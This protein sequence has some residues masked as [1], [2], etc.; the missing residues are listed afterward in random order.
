MNI[1]IQV[2]PI[3][4]YLIKEK[5]VILDQKLSTKVKNNNYSYQEIKYSRELTDTHKY[6]QI[7]TSTQRY[8]QVLTDT[9]KYSQIL[10]STHRYSQILTSTH[11]YS[12]VLTST[13]RY[14]QI[15][16]DTHRYS[17]ILT[18]THKY[19]QVLTSTHK[20]SQVLTDTSTYKHMH[21]QD[22]YLDDTLMLFFCK[23]LQSENRKLRNNHFSMFINS[24]LVSQTPN[25]KISVAILLQP[26][27]SEVSTKCRHIYAALLI[28][29]HHSNCSSMSL[30]ILAMLSF[31]EQ[32]F[33]QLI[34]I[35]TYPPQL[36][37]LHFTSCC[38]PLFCYS[39]NLV[40]PHSMSFFYNIF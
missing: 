37:F 40:L 26:L 8:S 16:T 39:C 13:H 4:Q 10:T 7:L 5:L 25:I 28:I 34:Y 9:H 36:Y 22:F 12:Q 3:R 15:L 20:Y 29:L 30:V 19:S 2:N 35:S 33:S 14:S 31:P 21:C 1:V 6:S 27:D 32:F 18:S 23:L 17:Q 38:N 11:R 24:L